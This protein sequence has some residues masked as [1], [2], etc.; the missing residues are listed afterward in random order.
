MCEGGR[1]SLMTVFT[2]YRAFPFFQKP[3]HRSEGGEMM[4]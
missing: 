1:E 2:W 3:P 4:V